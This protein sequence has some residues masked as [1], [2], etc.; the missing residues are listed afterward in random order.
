M[1]ALPTGAAGAA[2]LIG[3]P[4]LHKSFA[5]MDLPMWFGYFI[6]AAELAGAIGLLFPPLA[7]L[8]ATYLLPI[9]VGAT[10][11]HLAVDRS[12]PLFAFLLL[13][14]CV[15]VVLLRHKQSIWFPFGDTN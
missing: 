8:A 10:Y 3:S 5:A 9:M 2:K 7:V 1:L 12:S 6:G 14:L 4:E 15:A 11:Y 13:T